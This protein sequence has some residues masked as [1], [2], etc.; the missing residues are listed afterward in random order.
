M[1]K[2]LLGERKYSVRYDDG[3][4]QSPTGEGEDPILFH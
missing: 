2:A 1:R 4:A 3:K